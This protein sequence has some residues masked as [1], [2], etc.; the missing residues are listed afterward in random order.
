MEMV[1]E[2]LKV[3]LHLKTIS[4]REREEWNKEMEQISEEVK[5][6]RPLLWKT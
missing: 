4:E 2:W 5:R 3:K 6:V 1:I